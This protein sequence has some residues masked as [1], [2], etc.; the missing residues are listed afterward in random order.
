M[1][2]LKEVRAEE[3]FDSRKDKTILVTIKTL[4][5]KKFS[6]SSPTGK[7]TG[8]Y[9]A[10]SYKKSLKEDIKKISELSEYLTCED[11]SCFED[12][13]KVEEIC[14]EQIG[15]N[16]VFAIE[17][18]ILKA[19][20]DY[21]K[22][23]VWQVVKSN[24]EK[25][26]FPKF[27]GNCIG[28]GKHSETNSEEKKPDFQEFLIISEDS[29]VNKKAYDYAED[30]IKKFDDKF[31]SETNDEGAWKTS[32]NEKLVLDVLYELKEK[33]KVEIGLDIAAS[34][35]YKRKKYN[36]ENPK[37]KRDSE[38]QLSYV[39]NLIK[40]Y[41]L[42]YVEDAFGE[43][44]FE[45][46]AKLKEKTKCLIVGDDLT[47]TNPKRLEKAIKNKSINAVIVKPNQIGS[48]IKV[49]KVCN[50]A[51]KNKIKIVF[52]HRSGE[53]EEDILADLAFGFQADLF[54]VGIFGKEREAK[55]NRM[56][57][58]MKEI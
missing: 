13:E 15:A 43:E 32:L 20:A 34:S 17:S 27:V 23:K 45:S 8:K 33:F 12:L 30:L 47:V 18:C 29:K 53:T 55:I 14:E 46:F 52:S 19:I 37:L 39:E 38:E 25:N 49:K 21:N 3:I 4:Q 48:L 10:K 2:G 5:G 50:L 58:I 22:V 7:S 6:A 35:F 24:K 44:D 56:N 9:E 51:R 57:Q 31:K 42:L 41:G 26:K 36:Y 1:V 16:S 54:K 28:G 40:N 11:Y